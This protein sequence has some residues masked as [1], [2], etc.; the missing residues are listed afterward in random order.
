M[1][2]ASHEYEPQT[3]ETA[4]APDVQ[5]PCH[6]LAESGNYAVV[7]RMLIEHR[8]TRVGIQ[9]GHFDTSVKSMHYL[10]MYPVSTCA[11]GGMRWE[12]TTPPTISIHLL[13]QV[14]HHPLP[15]LSTGRKNLRRRKT[16]LGLYRAFERGICRY[17]LPSTAPVVPRQNF[18]PSQL[19]TNQATPRGTP[20]PGLQSLYSREGDGPRVGDPENGCSLWG[21]EAL[22]MGEGYEGRSK[23]RT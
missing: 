9:P 5:N 2:W 13:S 21:W 19:G 16:E 3:P 18:Y 4:G 8:K 1:E 12:L 7:I 17:H 15:D 6:Y 11:N 10:S 23:T 20:S 22:R 14:A